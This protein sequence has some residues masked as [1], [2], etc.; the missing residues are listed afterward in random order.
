MIKQVYKADENGFLKEIYVAEV[1]EGGKILNEDKKDL[2]PIDPPHGL[3]KA[4]W[5]GEEWIEGELEEERTNRESQYL[6]DTLKPSPS[7][8]ADAELEIKVITMLTELGVIQ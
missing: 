4:R 2:I 6:L 5:T 7:E 1:D 8:L 3:F